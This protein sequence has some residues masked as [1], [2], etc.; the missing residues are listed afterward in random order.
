MTKAEVYEHVVSTSGRIERLLKRLGG[1]GHGLVQQTNSIEPKLGADLSAL[2]QIAGRFRNQVLHDRPFTEKGLARF[3]GATQQAI[4][5]LEELVSAWELQQIAELRGR[6]TTQADPFK[7]AS[8]NSTSTGTVV[9][10][11]K[12]V[13]VAV[14]ALGALGIFMLS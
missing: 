3:N 6:E 12:V 7:S 4:P 13:G 11:F 5:V 10:A 14:L 1:T 9:S 8:S 2:L